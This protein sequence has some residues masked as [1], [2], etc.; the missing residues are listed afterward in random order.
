MKVLL[1]ILLIL[2]AAAGLYY[3]SA[4]DLDK[5]NRENARQLCIDELYKLPPNSNM[6]ED[7]AGF[8]DCQAAIKPAAGAA[9]IR[10]Q[11]RACMDQFGKSGVMARCEKLN[12]ELKQRY[13]NAKHIRCDCFYENL[14]DLSADAMMST[15]KIQALNAEQRRAVTEQAIAACNN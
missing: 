1:F 9:S 15:S 6:I 8:C 5:T 3:Y 11:G 10:A 13:T 14:M 7:A 4:Y 2:G 12:E